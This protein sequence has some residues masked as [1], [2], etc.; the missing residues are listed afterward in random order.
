MRSLRSI[1]KQ[2]ASVDIRELK[3]YLRR[4]L[5]TSTS[6]EYRNTSK[7]ILLDIISILR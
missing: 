1:T 6:L 4:Y 7:T 5:I 2:K 3:K